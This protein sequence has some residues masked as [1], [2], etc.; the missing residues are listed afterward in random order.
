MPDGTRQ[1]IFN[2]I[3]DYK[4]HHDGSA[5][6]ITE[7]AKALFLHYSTVRYHLLVL[8]TEGRIR[9]LGRRAIEIVGGEWDMPDEEAGV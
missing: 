4:R 3:V 7:M 8:E 2:Y 9:V 6:S 5:P 1:Q